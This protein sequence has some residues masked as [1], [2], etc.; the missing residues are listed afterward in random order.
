MKKH[1]KNI[2]GFALVVAMLVFE[3][4]WMWGFF[5]SIWFVQGAYFGETFLIETVKKE[6]SPI[7]YWA[8]LTL[9]F[10]MAIYSFL[11]LLYPNY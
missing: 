11:A 7:I 2:L 1:W 6:D 10:A 4:D 3:M 9:W 8:I 5:F